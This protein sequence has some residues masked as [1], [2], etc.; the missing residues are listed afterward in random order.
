MIACRERINHTA[1]PE[2][3]R[4]STD[5]RITTRAIL[6]GVL[7]MAGLLSTLQAQQIPDLQFEPSVSNPAYAA[8]KGPLVLVDAAHH[9]FHT[10]DTRYHVFAKVLREDGYVV[11]P[12]T[13]PFTKDVLKPASLLVIANAIHPSNEKDW[14]L[15]TPSAFS[16]AE[17]RVVRDFVSAGGSLLLIA[18]HMPFPGAAHDLAAAFGFRFHNGFATDT[19]A[20][21][22]PGA[23]AELDAFEKSNG[24]LADHGIT[25]GSSPQTAVSRVVTFTGQAFEI[26]TSATSILTFDERFKIL[27]PD[28]AWKF[29]QH[30][31]RIPIKGFSQGAV[32]N[33]GKGKV[34]VF[35]EAAMFTG[36][37]KGKDRIPF[38][39]NS[40]D[41]RENLTFLLNLMHWL[42]KQTE[43]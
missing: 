3:K 41:A 2:M 25:R 5:L 38:G 26:P 19:T 17:I 6:T 18:D 16:A 33:Y 1:I 10:I 40:P 13:G 34:A 8:N 4:S 42:D 31:K 9:N 22:F 24:T 43:D 28:T 7:L 36:Q 39:L 30:T 11:R 14:I 29:S 32:M 23:K 35:G 15:P 27:L 21:L 20:G 12:N 37:L